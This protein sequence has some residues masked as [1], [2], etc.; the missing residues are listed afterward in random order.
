MAN[1]MHADTDET[2]GARWYI[3]PRTGERFVSVTTVLSN[4]AKY[5]LPDWAAKLTADAA[6]RYLPRLNDSL[7]VDPCNCTGED[8]CGICR[9]CIRDWLARRHYDERDK[10]ASLGSRLHEAAEHHALFGSGGHVD[11]EVQ[12]FLTQYLRWVE[13]WKPSYVATEMT[14]ISRKWGYAGTLDGI[15]VYEEANLPERFK[16]LAGLN[17]VDDI[18]TGKSLDIPKG[19]QIVAYANADSVLLPDGSEEPMP[20]IG[21]GI[22]LHIR[23]ELV[24]VRRV[25]LSPANLQYFIH[26]LRVT[27]G[28]GAGLN[29]VL[30]RPFTLKEK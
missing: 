1:P 20:P 26:L 3:H 27:E 23:P 12:P 19:W 10:A 14:V 18:K 13:A 7:N 11:D 22:V 5:G 28:L 6:Y 29:S 21:G 24:Q 17:V 30:S 9:V 16:D 15:A 25:E 8:A 4:I 2:T